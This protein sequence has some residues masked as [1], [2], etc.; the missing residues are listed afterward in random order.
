MNKGVK[1]KGTK[2]GIV[3]IIDLAFNLSELKK[4]LASLLKETADY[5]NKNA[6]SL[7]FN[8]TGELEDAFKIRELQKLVLDC[9][10]IIDSNVNVIEEKVILEKS[11][12]KIIRSS[13]RAGNKFK[14]DG[15]VILFGDLNAGAKIEITG[16]FVC[17][18]AVYG[19]VHAGQRINDEGEYTKEEICVF[20][21]KIDSPNVKVKNEL[22]QN[23]N[24][25]NWL[26]YVE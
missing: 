19:I 22:I 24:D 6:V 13:L 7:S 10:F 3:F 5:F 17:I 9:G 25:S 18:G 20:A 1:L 2:K 21:S 23:V 15:N 14:F 12:T 4:S 8:E 11:R 26:Y 16:S